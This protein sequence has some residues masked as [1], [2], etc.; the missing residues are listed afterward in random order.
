MDGHAVSPE[1]RVAEAILDSVRIPS[2]PEAAMNLL[3]TCRDT[4]SS[5]NE[6]VRIIELDP[7]LC[8]RLLHVANSTYFGQRGQ[9]STLTRAAV[10]LGNQ[11]LRAAA[12]GFFLASGLDRLGHK[13]FDLREFWRDSILRACLGRQLAR[14]VDLHP[15]E[16]AFLLGMLSDVGSL[17]LV[18]HFGGPY[19]DVYNRERSDFARRCEVER[20]AFGTD[21]GR[22][23]YA[24]ARR[25]GFPE[26]LLSAM[27]HRCAEPPT[28]RTAF[29]ATTLWQL[30]YF[31]AAVPFAVDRQTA[32]LTSSL[33]RL[34]VTA[35]GLSFEGLS[36]AFTLAI[37][38]FNILG[39]VFS[40]VSPVECDPAMM[41]G[42]AERLMNS[43]GSE[44][45]DAVAT[46]PPTR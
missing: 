12:L 42:E 1:N 22:V 32:K 17:I 39:N 34:A 20:Q 43:L 5:A 15:A 19:A 8:A 6:I 37:E 35:F 44:V 10:V 9:V 16:Q 11:H 18:T 24:L 33:R 40:N 29:P 23:A 38:Q 4:R 36:D 3:L 30:A 27:A 7:A 26:I 28:M 2:L 46:T 25:W 21:H 14:A 41:A 13:G 31:C 45:L